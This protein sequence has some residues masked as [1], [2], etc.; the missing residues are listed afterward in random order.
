MILHLGVYDI[1]Y[2]HVPK[3]YRANQ[4]KHA[5]GTETTGDVANDLE[6]RYHIMESFFDFKKQKIAVMIEKSAAGALENIL[7]GAPITANPLQQATAD[8]STEFKQFLSTQEVESIGLRGVP[9]RA[10]LE[11]V[12]HRFKN[13]FGK[14][15]GKGKNRTFVKNPRRPSFIDTGLYQ[16]TM[17]VWAD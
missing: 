15:V 4:T 6:R 13:P 10:A 5:E 9:T 17:T 16:A 12:N 7:M 1:P 3:E 14:Y 11:G 2:A 8:I